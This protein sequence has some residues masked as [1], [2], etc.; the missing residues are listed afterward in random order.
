MHFFESKI[1]QLLD[2]LM[3]F[4]MRLCLHM[5][6]MLKMSRGLYNGENFKQTI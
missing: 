6:R 5:Q 3:F 1:Q 4:E 2:G